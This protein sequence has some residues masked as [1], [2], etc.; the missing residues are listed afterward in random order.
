LLGARPVNARA[1]CKYSYGLL[2]RFCRLADSKG[3]AP[4]KTTV[5]NILLFTVLHC[6][7]LRRRIV[8]KKG[9][10]PYK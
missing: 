5:E 3:T 6:F 1:H 8:L 7:I 2:P 9:S 4:V 10:Y